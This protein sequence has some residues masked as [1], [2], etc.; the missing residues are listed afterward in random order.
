[1]GWVDIS[2]PRL[3]VYFKD[4][5]FSEKK[6]LKTNI[7]VSRKLTID[8]FVVFFE[9]VR[10]LEIHLVEGKVPLS[11]D[12]VY[13]LKCQSSGARP[14]AVMSWWRGTSRL[15]NHKE[16]VSIYFNAKRERFSEITSCPSL[17]YTN[18]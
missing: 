17:T 4:N 1:M 13:T 6:C 5:K 11:A 14:A 12:V 16:V 3:L 15:K 2:P 10:P 7:I 8:S 9:I 18:Y